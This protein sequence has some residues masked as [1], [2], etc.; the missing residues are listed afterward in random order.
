MG[1]PVAIQCKKTTKTLDF[2]TVEQEI[3]KA[4]KF[5]GQISTLF[6]ATTAEH[7]AVL[8]KQLRI[9]SEERARLGK[10]SVGALFWDDVLSA[11]SLNPNVFQAHYPQFTLGRSP[12]A[13]P[14]RLIACL[15]LGYYGA[16]IRAFL[17]LVFGEFGLMA[18]TDPDVFLAKLR[19]LDGRTRQLL[20]DTEAEPIIEALSEVREGCAAPKSDSSDWDPVEVWAD[21]ATAR[22]RDIA[23]F[24]PL[25]ESNAL[26]L[27]AKLGR[28]YH[29]INDAPDPD[30]RNDIEERL[31]KVLPSSSEAAI[32]K[33]I[34]QSETKTSG[35]SW[36]VGV[37]SLADRELRYR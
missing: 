37:F 14:E 26:M 6:L 11:L 12:T 35:Y 31:R 15:E 17:N 28:I 27:G 9:L 20:S 36:A 16:D 19:V 8:Q 2:S 34:E 5:T 18:Q 30:L 7:D 21:R 4:E 32:S 1:R 13:T 22:I 3:D 23:S 33:C 24:L 10:F 25:E 29:H